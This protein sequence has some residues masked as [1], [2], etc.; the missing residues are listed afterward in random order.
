[1]ARRFARAG[2]HLALSYHEAKPD[3]PLE[4]ISEGPAH[5]C[6]FHLDV[7]N[8]AAVCT[9]VRQ[10]HAE[11]GRIDVLVNCTGTVGPIGPLTTLQTRDW[12]RTVEVNL[13]GSFHLA[14][15]VV[16]FMQERGGGKIIFISGGGAAYGR[17]YFTA[18]S[19]SKAALVRFTESLAEE[20]LAANIQVNAI[21]PGPVMSRMWRQMRAAGAAG[22]P[23]LAAE[24]KHMEETGGVAPDRAAALALFL[25]SEE[26]N[27]L[28]G[29]LISAIH[30]DWENLEN[31]MGQIAG[32]DA[33]TL[34]R[35]PMPQ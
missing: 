34:R 22:G 18:Y 14:R 8:E 13:F 11:F 35:M 7:T 29:R 15:A 28:T 24:L 4:S 3:G 26:S 6:R 2:A 5:V 16:P 21:A 27:S 10:A 1:V 33:W 19:A 12:I 32:S 31:R 9:F 25:A 20:L 30:D 17:P 23:R